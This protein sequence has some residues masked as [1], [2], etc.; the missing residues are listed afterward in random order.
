MK[1]MHAD[2]A[3]AHGK[4]SGDELINDDHLLLDEIRAALNGKAHEIDQ[5]EAEDAIAIEARLLDIK[6]RAIET[7][8]K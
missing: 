5:V 7:K 2:E 8:K 4:W 3:H 6:A 1:D